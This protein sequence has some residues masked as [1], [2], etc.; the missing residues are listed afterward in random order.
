M[1][2]S[3]ISMDPHKKD[4]G[5]IL[6]T[7]H[8]SSYANFFRIALD[9]IT[10][11]AVDKLALLHSV[12]TFHI[13]VVARYIPFPQDLIEDRQYRH[14]CCPILGPIYMPM[15]RLNESLSSMQQVHKSGGSHNHTPG[16]NLWQ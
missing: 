10:T 14:P 11:C 7:N 1:Q 6:G 4:E 15:P 2:T 5:R 13:Q 16:Y 12:H 8:R 3:H 9:R